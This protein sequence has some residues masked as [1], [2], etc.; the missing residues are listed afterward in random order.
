[1]KVRTLMRAKPVA[2]SA[3]DS[4]RI[5]LDIMELGRVRHI[6]VVRKGKLVGVVSQRDLFHASLSNVIG[7]PR[8]EQ[9][10]FLEGVKISEV[11]SAPPVSI[12][13]DASV[14]EAAALMAK[15]R[16][17][18]LPVVNGDEVVGIVTETDLL[19]HFASMSPVSRAEGDAKRATREAS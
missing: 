8:E 1:M 7:L 16:I 2:I 14:W 12:G 9:E 18:C 3:D 4:L 15:S 10:L 13:P 6:P 5:V 17:G 11:M 19:E